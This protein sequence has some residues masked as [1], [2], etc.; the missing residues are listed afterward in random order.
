MKTIKEVALQLKEKYNQ[1]YKE[2]CIENPGKIMN[3]NLMKIDPLEKASYCKDIDEVRAMKK[4]YEI[5]LRSATGPHG[6]GFSKDAMN[7]LINELE[8]ERI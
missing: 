1:Q 4:Y 8:N 5:S 3:G 7:E 2:W 6:F